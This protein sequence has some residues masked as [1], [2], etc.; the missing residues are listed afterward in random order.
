[1]S[2]LIS[3]MPS[4]PVPFLINMLQHKVCEGTHQVKYLRELLMMIQ[5]EKI[6]T[7]Q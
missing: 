7:L 4:E 5:S 2:K 3:E 6:F 1:M